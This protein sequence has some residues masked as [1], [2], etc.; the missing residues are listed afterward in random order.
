MARRQI[1]VP[2]DVAAEL[3][4]SQDRVLRELEEQLGCEI[5]LRGNLVTLDGE[6]EAVANAATV[7]PRARHARRPAATSSAPPPSSP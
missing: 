5:F 7:D 3:A 1:E 4:G 6:A 2:N